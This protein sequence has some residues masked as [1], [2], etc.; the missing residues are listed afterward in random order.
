MSAVSLYAKASPDFDA[1]LVETSDLLKRAAQE[2]SPLA[3]A[4]SLGAE[5]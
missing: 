1:K 5:D 3:Q 4:S 2:F